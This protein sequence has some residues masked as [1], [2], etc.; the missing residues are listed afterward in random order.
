[1]A[2]IGMA[3]VALD[4]SIVAANP[5]LI[6]LDGGAPGD[7]P[8]GTTVDDR[9][10]RSDRAVLATNFARATAGE[11]VRWESRWQPPLGAAI[12]VLLTLAPVIDDLGSPARFLLQI[13]DLT[14]RRRV[15]AAL[16]EAAHVDALTGIAN[17]RGFEDALHRAWEL[18]RRDD[19]AAHVVIADMDGLKAVNDE[20]GHAAGDQALQALAAALTV[21]A[22]ATDSVARIGGD[23]F[24][25]ILV[26]TTTEDEG[27][28][29]FVERVRSD[30]RRRTAGW[31]PGV[32]VSA[33]HAALAGMRTAEAAVAAADTAMYRMKRSRR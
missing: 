30:L 18:S 23:E 8:A 5:A 19:V 2:A 21:C 4:G 7:D 31:V 17:R 6:A 14:E 3:V 16:A 26:A 29:R 20:L 15:E 27:P 1:M 10:A 24:A 9:V 32:G 12:P 28:E 33:G 13:E 25:A 22:R 11:R